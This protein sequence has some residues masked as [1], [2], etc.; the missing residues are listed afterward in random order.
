METRSGVSHRSYRTRWFN[1]CRVTIQFQNRPG[2]DEPRGVGSKEVP[3]TWKRTERKACS[4]TRRSAQHVTAAVPKSALP[5]TPPK[6]RRQCRIQWLEI[7]TKTHENQKSQ[8]KAGIGVGGKLFSMM[9]NLQDLEVKKKVKKKKKELKV[10]KTHA[11]IW[12]YKKKK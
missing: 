11:K 3:N 1:I 8:G 5:A 2:V 7:T 12:I 9:Q 10:E 4:G 6:H